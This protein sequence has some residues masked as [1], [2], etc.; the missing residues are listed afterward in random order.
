MLLT[1]GGPLP[2]AAAVVRKLAGNWNSTG[3]RWGRSRW[4][5]ACAQGVMGA[6]GTPETL[7]WHAGSP[8]CRPFALHPTAAGHHPSSAAPL[9]C[10]TQKRAQEPTKLS[11]TFSRLRWLYSCGA[12]LDDVT[13]GVVH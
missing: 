12:C 4:Q 9:C 5:L 11:S 10:L 8:V 1:G 6:N 7:W 2:L 13:S 3:P